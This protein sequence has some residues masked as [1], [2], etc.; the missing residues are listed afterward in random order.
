MAQPPPT[1]AVETCYL[2][3]PNDEEPVSLEWWQNIPPFAICCHLV[4]K[5]TVFRRQLYW[6]H[7][8]ACYLRRHNHDHDHLNFYHTQENTCDFTNDCWHRGYAGF[9]GG[10]NRAGV[11]LEHYEGDWAQRTEFSEANPEPVDQRYLDF[12]EDDDQFND[13]EPMSIEWLQNIPPFNSCCHLVHK[14]T[15]WHQQIFW[16][17]HLQCSVHNHSAR[18]AEFSESGH[19]QCDFTWNCWSHG[20]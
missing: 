12:N 5:L 4:H 7:F 20:M 8:L 14:L 13:G 1:E 9:D 2:N 6:N 10:D 18:N 11:S 16:T 3:H 17:H 19:S 15:V